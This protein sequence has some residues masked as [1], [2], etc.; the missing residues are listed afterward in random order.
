[1]IEELQVINYWLQSK[2]PG[3][4]Y[5]Q[6]LD[7]SYFFATS[8]IVAWIEQFI[9]RTGVLPSLET[10]AAEFE[11]FK[12]LSDLDPIDY[13]VNVL[14]EQKAYT[15]YRPLLTKNAQLVSEGR[16]IDAMWQMV[17][18]V[19]SLLKK[20]T[21]KITRYDWVRDALERYDK[22]MEKHGQ[23]GLNG[24]TT[25]IKQLDEYTG[26]W[27]SDDLILLVGRTNEGKSF[28][29]TYF[30]Y[31]VWRSLLSTDI[32]NPVIYITTE[33]PEL[34]IAYRLD[35]LRAHFSNR[36]LNEGKLPDPQLYK[37]YLEELRKNKNGFLILSE[38]ANGGKP[39][40]PA[41]I[42]VIIEAE[43]PAFMVID[44]L[45]DLSDGIGE[46]DIRK[47]IV[48]VTNQI[49]DVNL[50]TQT[51]M[52]LIAQAGRASAIEGKKDP[53]ATPE[54]FQVQE[55]DNPAQKATR[56][57]TLRMINDVFKISL[58]KNRGGI[59]NVDVYMRVDLDTGIWEEIDPEETVF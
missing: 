44:Q 54:L 46:R 35:T 33:M 36:G 24:L 29:G 20:Y 1:M 58:K 56:V 12:I 37:E 13:L 57:L 18:E 47:R 30:A 22:Y 31:V 59:R 16:T 11:E 19:N 40:T 3:Y 38:E 6:G 51:P 25:G 15:E 4:L 48:N 2:E 8:D 28:V 14:K 7:H 43:K 39:F 32:T 23:Q 41:D 34:E 21:G 55:S 45:Y 52:M 50:Y 27:R 9:T 49:R 17:A 5:K 53:N 42:R 26:G 10:V